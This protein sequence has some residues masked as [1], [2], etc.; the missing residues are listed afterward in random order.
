MKKYIILIMAAVMTLGFSSCGSDYLDTTPNSDISDQTAYSTTENCA[1]AVNGLA[2]MM[3]KQYLRS[4]GMNGEGTILCWYN[5]CAGQD[6]NRCG[7]TGYSVIFN[8]EASLRQSRI[9]IYNYYIWYYYYKL[10]GNANAIIDNVDQATGTQEERDFIKA[11][12][13][14]Y[15]AFSYWRLCTFYCKRWAS[16]NNGKSDGVVL[17][18]KATDSSEAQ[19]DSLSTL[20]EVYDQIYADLNQA[21]SLFEESGLD[22]G[23]DQFYL[24]NLNV[25][26]AVLA[27][28]ALYRE[29][30]ATAADA[31]SKAREGYDLMGDTEYHAGFHTPN[32]EWLWGV[33][34][35]E[36][37]TLH[38][39]GFFAN[40]G[41]DASASAARNYPLAISKELIDSIP[42][43]DTRR[44]LYLVPQSTA[45]YRTMTDG[46]S[47]SAGRVTS[48]SAALYQRAMETG[49]MYPSGRVYGFMQ[50][51]LR[52]AFQPGGGSFNIFRA[53]EMIYTEA[54]ADVHLG[55]EAEA[56]DLLYEA[57]S[58]YD[59]DYEPTTATGNELLREI[60]LYRRFDLFGEGHDWT[61]VKRWNQDLVRHQLQRTRGANSPGSFCRTFAITIDKDDPQRWEFV[62][63]A[64]EVDYNSYIHET[65]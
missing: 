25:A 14:V 47:T 29:D 63:P 38:Y 41:S 31:A 21:I 1:M 16:S 64:R 8:N 6:G 40:I 5:D 27:R 58:P 9:W 30:W 28:A 51:K 24:P 52:C 54:E 12:A 22:R 61:D 59:P 7:L 33:Y 23:A 62:I 49:W 32:S 36:T 43:S 56:Q 13:L 37:Q 44:D 35:D 26:Y 10:I 34:E 11:Q 46:T 65:D 39:Y 17:R 15:R 18:L 42:E 60:K 48:S 4:Q 20:G 2:R 57:V 55:K 50:F 45:E 53:A 19:D 3:T